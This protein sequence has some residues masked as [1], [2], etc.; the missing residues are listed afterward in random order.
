MNQNESMEIQHVSRD[1][2]RS[3]DDLTRDDELPAPAHTRTLLAKFQTMENQTP[4]SSSKSSKTTPAAG[5]QSRSSSGSSTPSRR[6]QSSRSS[7]SP[8]RKPAQEETEEENKEEE[9]PRQGFARSLIGQWKSMELESVQL[10]APP[11]AK[12]GKVK[13]NYSLRETSSKSPEKITTKTTTTTTTRK[14]VTS[15]QP[16][17]TS[18]QV[19]VT[20]E[21]TDGSEL[22]PPAFT[23]NMLAKFQTMQAD[24]AGQSATVPQKSSAK[25][26][27]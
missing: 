9:L 10:G 25:K 7:A 6:T 15:S 5:G 17:E 8:E 12:E 27:C 24:A 13:R 1:I 2:I 21:D 26:V 3:T 18:T 4:A 20:S 22:P 19:V 23:K 16:E 11:Q 14:V